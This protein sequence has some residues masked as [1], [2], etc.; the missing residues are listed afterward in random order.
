M[1]A[2]GPSQGALRTAAPSPFA[3]FASATL[4]AFNTNKTSWIGLAVFLIVV[5]AAIFAPVLA[6]FDPNDQNILEKLRAP[7]IEHWLGTDS[8]GRDTLSR[9]LY[10]ARISL[11]IGVVSTLAAMV[12]GTA[13]GMLAGWHGGRLDTVTMQAMDVLLAF[14]SL[15][16]GLILVAML[17]PSMVNIIIAI[18]LTS[19]PPFARIARAPTIAVKERE[20]VDA[21]RALGYSDARILIVHILPNILPEILV[22]GSLWLANAIRTEA[23]L[24]FVG[25]GV[26]PPTATWGGMIREGF[27]NI[28]DSYWLALAPGVAILIV[29]F[30]LNL[31]GDGLRDAIDPK[32]KGEA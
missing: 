10:G 19:I 12:I 4:K 20:F 16:L 21:G 1:S 22:M 23:S 3:Y 24:A 11:I 32:L 9:L 26:K 14:P 15:I 27:E 31:L 17:G 13:I 29:I 6:P 30:A 5:V 18:A 25:L 28:L 2:A 7:T 8:F